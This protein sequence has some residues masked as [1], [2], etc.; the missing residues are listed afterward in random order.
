M[1]EDFSKKLMMMD[2][3]IDAAE[4]S[5]VGLEIGQQFRFDDVMMLGT[6]DFTMLGRPILKRVSVLATIEELTRTNKVI[7]FKKKRR[8]GYQRNNGHK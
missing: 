3:V 1:L 7:V 6:A 8:K 2:P 4:T 5:P